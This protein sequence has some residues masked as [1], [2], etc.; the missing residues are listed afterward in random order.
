MDDMQVLYKL[1]LII[2]DLPEDPGLAT[3]A[4]K[5]QRDILK[6]SGAWDR[7]QKEFDRRA[8]SFD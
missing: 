6:R 1:W 5:V 7:C 8:N 3:N 4:I 2:K